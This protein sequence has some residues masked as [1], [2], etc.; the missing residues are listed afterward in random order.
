V[1][2]AFGDYLA[3]HPVSEADL[4]ALYDRQL[5][6]LA[7]VQQYKLSLITVANEA[8]AKAFLAKL[9]KGEPFAKVAREKS[10]DGSKKD[11]GALEWVIPAQ[12]VPAIVTVIVNVPK[13]SIAAAPIQTSTG[14]NIVKVDDKRPFKAPSFEDSKNQLANLLAQ[15]L[16]MEYAQKLRTAAKIVE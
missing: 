10:I 6:E 8:E 2:L 4:R 11:G 15:Q 14:W 9:Q 1:D 3:K 12:I 13:G 5:K 16:R 7:D